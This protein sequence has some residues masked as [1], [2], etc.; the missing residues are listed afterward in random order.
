MNNIIQVAP[1]RDGK[2][3]RLYNSE[4]NTYYC[5]KP[6]QAEAQAACDRENK[7]INDYV[8]WHKKTY[9]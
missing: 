8:E 4:K 7:R 3:F 9:G 1:T 6:T 5:G 2:G